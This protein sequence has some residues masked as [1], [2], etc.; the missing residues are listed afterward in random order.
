LTPDFGLPMP[1]GT[2]GRHHY[3]PFFSDCKLVF[4]GEQSLSELFCVH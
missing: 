4:R 1:V 3:P 2:E